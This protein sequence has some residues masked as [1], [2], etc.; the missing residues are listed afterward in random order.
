MDCTRPVIGLETGDSLFFSD[1][2]KNGDVFGNRQYQLDNAHQ[3]F[4]AVEMIAP[5]TF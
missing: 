3:K 5:G 4:K 1:V 2:E